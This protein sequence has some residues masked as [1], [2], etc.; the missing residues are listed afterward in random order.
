MPGL[1]RKATSEPLRHVTLKK[2]QRPQDEPP[3]AVA[4]RVV[5][6]T[7]PG[8]SMMAGASFLRD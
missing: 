4:S 2:T 1:P 5:R 7:L 6:W 8:Q 3:G